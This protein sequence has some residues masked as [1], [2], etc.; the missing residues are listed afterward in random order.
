MVTKLRGLIDR[1][2]LFVFSARL[3]YLDAHFRAQSFEI[4]IQAAVGKKV[5]AR[6]R[7]APFRKVDAASTRPAL[8]VI[9]G[10]REHGRRTCV[11]ALATGVQD[12]LTKSGKTVGGGDMTRKRKLLD[13]Q[14]EGKRRMKSV[15]SVELNDNVFM[16]AM[17]L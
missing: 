2:V 5:L 14:K 10:L 1:Q 16:A 17:Q 3:P 9:L 15:G 6:E 8:S 7:I 11:A 4:V 13:K 12:V